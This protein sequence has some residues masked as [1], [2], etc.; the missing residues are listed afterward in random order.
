VQ[1]ARQPTDVY[2]WNRGGVVAIPRGSLLLGWGA[3]SGYLVR[4]GVYVHIAADSEAAVLAA[5]R[6]LE[7]WAVR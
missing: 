7:P 4:D 2:T 6:A 5:A 3:E 1:E